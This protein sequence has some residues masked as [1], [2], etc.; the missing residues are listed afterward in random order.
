MIKR[1]FGGSTMKD[2]NHYATRIVIPYQPSRV[3]IY[4][5]DNDIARGTSP[6]EFINDCLDFIHLCRQYI[7]DTEIYFLSIK[8][9]P[10]RIRYWNSMQEAN[11]MLADLALRYEKVHLIDFSDE[12]LN[13][14][15]QPIEGLYDKDRLHLSDRG[16]AI[17]MNAIAPY[18]N[19]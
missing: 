14:D 2:L 13:S 4:E 8:P 9:S 12:M 10:A 11:L 6:Q 5:G 15:G 19:E 18:L 7:P 3:F 1:G 17:L 16:Y